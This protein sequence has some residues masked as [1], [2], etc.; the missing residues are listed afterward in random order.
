[1][2]LIFG[3]TYNLYYNFRGRNMGK[4]PAVSHGSEAISIASEVIMNLD[5]INEMNV[6]HWVEY[7][8]I[9]VLEKCFTPQ[10]KTL[11]HEYIAY[12]HEF[13]MSYVIRKGDPEDTYYELEMLFDYYGLNYK[14][15][16]DKYKDDDYTYVRELYERYLDQLVGVIVEDVFSVLYN[17]KNF[18][19][20]FNQQVSSIIS[21]YKV[22][23]YP[24]FLKE[25]G[26]IKRCEYFPEWL[27]KGVF[28]RDKGRC[29]ICSTDLTKILNLD[30]SENYDHIIPLKLSGGNDPTNIQ[31]TCEHCNKSKG[32]R[33]CSF[34]NIASPYWNLD[35]YD[36]VKTYY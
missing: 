5:D 6:I 20:K 4:R 36:F 14:D 34:K 17:D 22:E 35:S 8:C 10:K 23:D 3:A 25:D 9:D 1:M 7:E 24:N 27:K 18:L 29:Q 32:A 12:I 13:G 21:Q 30:N 28:H 16:R 2:I 31:L 33:N 11:L 26:V 19:F 15:L